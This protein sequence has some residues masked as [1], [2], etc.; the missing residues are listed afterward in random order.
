M[1]MSFFVALRIFWSWRIWLLVHLH[2]HPPTLSLPQFGPIWCILGLIRTLSV[3]FGVLKLWTAAITPVPG[4]ACHL[5]DVVWAK[6]S[7]ITTT[8]GR[9][10]AW[11]ESRG[12]HTGDTEMACL[13]QFLGSF[14]FSVFSVKAFRNTYQRRI[15]LKRPHKRVKAK[16][17]P[18]LE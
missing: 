4:R 12:T 10:G 14:Y 5:T 8:C 6:S 11:R 18:N 9:A 7:S 15:F 16:N 17:P 13:S 1:L 3:H 2:T